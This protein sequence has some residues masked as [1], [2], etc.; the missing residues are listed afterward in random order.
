MN[1][2]Y[3]AWQAGFVRRWHGNYDLC[4][5][6]DYDAGHQGR[7]FILVLRLFPLASRALLVHAG[8]HD[9]G[10]VAVGDVSYMVKIANPELRPVLDGLEAAEIAA[11]GLPQPDISPIEEKRLKL[12]DWLDAW[13]WMLRHKPSLAVR[14][15]W[16]AQLAATLEMA[17]SLGVKDEVT[18]LA[19]AAWGGKLLG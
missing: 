5:T 17:E 12:C 7:V 14:E 4:D 2:T 9:Q 18:R 19:E 16:S 1:P 8:T 3:R 13:L 15:D 10:E 6:V 11:Q